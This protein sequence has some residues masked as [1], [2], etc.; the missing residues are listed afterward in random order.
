MTDNIGNYFP[1]HH[2]LMQ[3]CHLFHNYIFAHTKAF[4]DTKYGFMEGE[5]NYSYFIFVKQHEPFGG[6]QNNFL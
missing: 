2:K 5:T 4:T 1:K 3:R 6:R